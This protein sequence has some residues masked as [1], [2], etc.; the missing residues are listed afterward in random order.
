MARRAL[1]NFLYLD[2]D[3]LHTYLAQIEG[4]L[5][6]ES[7]DRAEGSRSAKVEG[8]LGS[9]PLNVGGSV[10][11]GSTQASER[12][13]VQTDASEFNRLYEAMSR[14]APIPY[15]EA[16]DR[17]FWDDLPRNE[18]VELQ[19]NIQVA[20]LVKT[21]ELMRLVQDIAPSLERMGVTMEGL[22][23][24]QL[25][26]VSE[27]LSAGGDN[28]LFVVAELAGS[29]G[30]KFACELKRPYVP[31]ALEELEGEATVIGTIKRKLNAGETYTIPG[32]IP[33]MQMLTAKQ[34]KA[35]ARDLAKGPAEAQVGPT[36]IKDPGALL[37]TL[38]IHR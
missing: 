30:F 20:G 8:T 38:A 1:R 35:A 3:L 36:M 37:T 22:D 4:G 18:L 10:G 12:T 29:P 9:G 28:K 34:Q 23:T 2:S 15:L 16:I 26:A 24:R 14:E 25:A 11:K 7:Q 13:I 21:M 27:V 17:S 5:Y 19:A 31:K 6:S 33:G 32:L